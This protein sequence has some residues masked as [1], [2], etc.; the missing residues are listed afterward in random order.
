MAKNEG[1]A[2]DAVVKL[3]EDR[4]GEARDDVRRPEM[5]RVGPPVDLR[6]R[7]G[8]QEYAI[9]HTEIEAFPGRIRTDESLKQLITPIREALSGTL[10]GPAEYVMYVPRDTSLRVR[11]SVLR[12]VIEELKRWTRASANTLYERHA[13]EL[14]EQRRSGPMLGPIKGAPPSFGKDIQLW[15]AASCS[16]SEGGTLRVG[17]WDREE[18]DPEIERRTRLRQALAKKCPKLLQC[19][20]EGTRTVL[21]LETD[22]FVLTNHVSVGQALSPMLDEREDAPDEIYLVESGVKPWMVW[23]MKHDAERWP[24]ERWKESRFHP[25]ELIELREVDVCG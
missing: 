13:H 5:N 4:L 10:P 11:K 20:R 25:D 15:I 7:L 18:E 3:L 16:E 9:E 2:C 21:V 19:K 17:R 23:M 24:I 14:P 12:E 6:F 22:D 8:H 1:K